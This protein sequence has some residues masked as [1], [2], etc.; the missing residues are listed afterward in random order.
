MHQSSGDLYGMDKTSI[1]LCTVTFVLNLIR[2]IDLSTAVSFVA[3]MAGLSTMGY[4][5]VK[6]YYEFIKNKRKEQ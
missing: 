5:C 6:I 1:A 3:L 2:S 4:N